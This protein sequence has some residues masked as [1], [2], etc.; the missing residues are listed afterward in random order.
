MK[1]KRMFYLPL[2]IF[3]SLCFFALPQAMAEVNARF[4]ASKMGDMCHFD[5]NK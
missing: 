3:C 5:P 4:D 2:I 1:T